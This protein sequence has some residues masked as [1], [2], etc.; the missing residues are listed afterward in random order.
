MQ[1]EQASMFGRHLVLTWWDAVSLRS[2]HLAG[3]GAIEHK[4]Q[5][6]RVG[7][8]VIARSSLLR[9]SNPFCSYQSLCSYLSGLTLTSLEGEVCWSKEQWVPTESPHP[10][11]A[12]TKVP[13]HWTADILLASHA[14]LGDLA[15]L[16]PLGPNESTRHD[17]VSPYLSW[18]K[19]NL[20]Q[21]RT[22]PCP[23]TLAVTQGPAG[24]SV[25]ITG[26]VRG[27]LRERASFCSGL[28]RSMDIPSW[29]H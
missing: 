28:M 4:E 1:A 18:R 10:S 25:A 20:A 29:L 6:H 13:P 23:S 19:G 15:L 27:A 2:W 17:A 16:S 11:P 7:M 21:P 8:S 5:C 22:D 12:S 14:F 26:F 3:A 24:L 9:S